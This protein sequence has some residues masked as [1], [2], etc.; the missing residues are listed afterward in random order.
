VA[1]IDAPRVT[2]FKIE[3]FGQPAYHVPQLAQFLVRSEYLKAPAISS[4]EVRLSLGPI[5][6]VAVQPPQS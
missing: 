4:V 2:I 6:G 3:Y 5:F 1:Q